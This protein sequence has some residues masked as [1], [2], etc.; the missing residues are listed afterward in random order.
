MGQAI[1][2][3]LPFRQNGKAWSVQ[4]T[5]DYEEDC[6]TGRRYATLAIEQGDCRA[7]ENALASMPRFDQDS[8]IEVGFR[9][10]ISKAAVAY[11]QGTSTLDPTIAH[12]DEYVRPAPP[13]EFRSPL[14]GQ[15]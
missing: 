2:K 3:R 7:I 9:Y 1:V 10:V 5:G 6:A 4:P 14:E 8:G 13:D 11:A 15:I 12:L